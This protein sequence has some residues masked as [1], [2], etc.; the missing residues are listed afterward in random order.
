MVFYLLEKRGKKIKRMYKLSK[1]K[2]N[3]S[4]SFSEINIGSV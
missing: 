2:Q 1:V 4:P 3:L